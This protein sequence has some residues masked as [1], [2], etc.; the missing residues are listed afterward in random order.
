MIALY[1]AEEYLALVV[2]KNSPRHYFNVLTRLTNRGQ[3][4]SIVDGLEAILTSPRGE[5]Y[6]FAWNLFYGQEGLLHTM[7]SNAHPVEIPP[8]DSRLLGIGFIGPDSGIDK[9][10]LWPTGR[11]QCEITGRVDHSTDRQ[12]TNLRS[13]FY[14]DI[15]TENIADLRRWATADDVAWEHLGDPDNAVGIPVFIEELLEL[16]R[17]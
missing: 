1:P 17:R 3:Q 15:S 4:K 8:D 7:S 11:Y 5:I 14:M 12:P 10:Y 6:K 2:Q 9:L 13:I 16:R